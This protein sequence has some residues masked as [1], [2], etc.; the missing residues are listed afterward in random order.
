MF[1]DIDLRALADLCEFRGRYD[2]AADLLD[3]IDGS[4]GA[5]D[6]DRL[7]RDRSHRLR[8]RLN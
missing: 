5:P 7:L 1:A 4:L 3:R 8:S 6:A 2:D